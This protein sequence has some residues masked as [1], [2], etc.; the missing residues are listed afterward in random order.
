MRTPEKA[1]HHACR[2]R[3]GRRRPELQPNSNSSGGGKE[4]DPET[5]APDGGREGF[6]RRRATGGGMQEGHVFNVEAAKQAMANILSLDLFS[7]IEV[8]PRLDENN[9][10]GLIVEIKLEVPE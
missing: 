2:R 8:Q 9:E 10:G 7:N 6:R 3:Q 5:T 4:G 1:P